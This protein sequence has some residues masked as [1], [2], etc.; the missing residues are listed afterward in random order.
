MHNSIEALRA[1]I[2]S[3]EGQ[4]A[5]LGDMVVDLALA[6]LRVR[7]AS[8]LRPAWVRHRQFTVLFADVVGSTALADGLLAE[9]TLALLNGTMQRM[10]D[11]IEAR[12]GRVLR[13]TDDGVKAAF[14]TDE[15]RED[16]AERAM[17]VGLAICQAGLEQAE[18]VQRLH[19][20]A[21]FAVRVGVHTVDVALRFG[22]DAD[23]TAIGAAVNIAARMEQSAP[24]GALRI[25][26]ETW[27]Q[28]R[29]LFGVEAQP[30]LLV[31]GIA[32]PMTTYLMHAA[33]DRGVASFRSAS[34]GFD[35]QFSVGINT[36]GPTCHGSGRQTRSVFRG[37]RKTG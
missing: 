3:L 9:Y 14:G 7:L 1:A 13:F 26:H 33:L 31:K 20:V 4:R 27:S 12:Q 18:A 19:G 10:A 28:V 32:A 25:S 17:R 24:P 36:C 6:P 11:I 15:V 35:G 37:Q 23:N 5:Q 2:T 8:L 21:D 30:P 29:G 16:D 34:V 22:V